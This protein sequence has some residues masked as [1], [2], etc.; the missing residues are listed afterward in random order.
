MVFLKVLFWE[1]LVKVGK[2]LFGIIL[3]EKIGNI[4]F[5]KSLLPIFVEQSLFENFIKGF[6]RT[7]C[8]KE[9]V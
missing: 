6:V 4:L 5:G 3:S 1:N 9:C 8:V 7:N 2:I